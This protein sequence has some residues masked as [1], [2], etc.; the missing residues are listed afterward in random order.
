MRSVTALSFI[1]SSITLV[2]LPSHT[3]HYILYH[4]LFDLDTPLQGHED[5]LL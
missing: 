4:I 5:L 3:V 1:L 2:L